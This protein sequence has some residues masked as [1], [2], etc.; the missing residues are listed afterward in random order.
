MRS[1]F[2]RGVLRLTEDLYHELKKPLGTVIKD[3]RDVVSL[4]RDK[5]PRKI[6][7]VGDSTTRALMGD[8]DPDVVILDNRIMRKP[9]EPVGIKAQTTIRVRNPRSHITMGAWRAI[10][11]AMASRA[12][13][14]IVV[15]GEEDLLTLPAIKLAPEGSVV[16]Y[17]QPNE[18]LVVVNVDDQ[19]KRRAE[20]L[21]RSMVS[22]E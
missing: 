12:R 17:G 18:G 20:R 2:G 22:V 1:G 8:L 7:F 4:I 14:K 10:D 21:L 15:K 3:P 16:L 6:I 5:R 19:A 11:M 13:V 9:I